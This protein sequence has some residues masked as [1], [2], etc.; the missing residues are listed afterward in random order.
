MTS[1]ERAGYTFAI[2]EIIAVGLVPA[3]SKFAA[4][5]VDPLAY[6]AAASVVAA[7]LACTLAARRGELAPIFDRRFAPRLIAIALC[8]TVATTLLLLFGARI[9]DGVS[10]ALLL[11]AEPIYS[12]AL[13]TAVS[14]KAAPPRQLG[15]TAL[16][17]TGVL[18][19]LFDGSLSV[20]VGGLLILLAP[21]GWQ[22]SHV[23]ALGV[24]PPLSPYALTAARY[25]YGGVA[26]CAISLAATVAGFRGADGAVPLDGRALAMA[27]FHG[28]V[29]FFC[30]TLFWYETIRRI[31][32]ARAT[33]LVTPCE[34]LI[35]VLLV[36]GLLG[37]VPTRW[38][39]LGLVVLLAGIFLLVRNDPAASRVESAA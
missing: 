16:I 13:V 22:I 28:V 36:W 18:L 31:D 8:G 25:F 23:L 1:T 2:L 10:T 37:S 38:Q 12:L 35:S 27:V 9:T 24:M 4:E 29:L 26:L 17:L 5:R 19:V 39:F 3:F 33:A 15:G 7:V 14:G 11:Q 6:A 21:L 20:G 32:L 34:P 30:G